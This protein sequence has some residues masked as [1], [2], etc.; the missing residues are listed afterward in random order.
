[1]KYVEFGGGI[2]DLVNDI[3][4]YDAFSSLQG[5][6]TGSYAKVGLICHNPHAKE[7]F[8]FWPGG[9]LLEVHDYGYWTPEEDA[10]YRAANAMP[11]KPK[12]VSRPEWA[13]FSF[14]NHP[15][16]EDALSILPDEYIV[17]SVSAGTSDR[18]IPRRITERI[19]GD[20]AESGMPWDVSVGRS[21]ERNGK[22]EDLV[23]TSLILIDELSLPATFN[24]VK[25]PRCKGVVACH[26]AISILAGWENKPQLLL[27]DEATQKRHFEKKDQ[28]SWYAFDR[29]N[30]FHGTF[31]QWQD[32]AE[33][34]FHHIQCSTATT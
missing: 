1:M 7:L 21:Y 24:V 34:F 29:Q 6:P 15:S 32:R 33:Q 17:F 3:Y 26:S 28:W 20:M 8:Q 9:H 5:M 30:V 19:M 25:D 4:R 27:Y 2:G 12:N 10:G 22:S 11:P 18:N 13:V 23:N 31:D 14:H 16:D